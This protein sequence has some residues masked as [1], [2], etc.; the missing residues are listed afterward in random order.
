MQVATVDPVQKP[1]VV[2]DY[3]TVNAA[4]TNFTFQG[5]TTYFVSGSA[6]LVGVTTLEGGAVLKYSIGGTLQI[7]GVLNCETT[8]YRPAVFTSTN[9]NSVGD[10]INGSS[11]SP[12]FEDVNDFLVFDQT[13]V[14]LHDLRFCYSEQAIQD[15]PEPNTYNIWNCQFLNVNMSIWAYDVNLYNVLFG[16]TTGQSSKIYNAGFSEVML[17]GNLNAQNVTSDSGNSFIW[18]LSPG[19]TLA[20]TNCLITSQAITNTDGS[21]APLLTNAVVYLPS[22]TNAVYQTVG[23]GSYYL[24]NGSSYRSYG[25]ANIDLDL[26]VDLM[27]KTTW[28]PLVYSNKTFSVTTNLSPRA[29][30]DNTGYPD[31]GYHYAPIDYIIGASTIASNAAVNLTPGTAVG[32]FR[33][34][35]TATQGLFVSA[36]AQFNSSGTA[37]N[38]CQF[39]PF[40]SVQEGN[41]SW[42]AGSYGMGILFGATTSSHP[43]KMNSKFTI[44]SRLSDTGGGPD[45]LYASMYGVC[46]Y[47][48][49]E[50]YNDAPTTYRPSLY[51][52]N[53]L[54]SRAFVA[55]WDSQNAAS[56][57]FENCTFFN[58]CLSVTR[59]AGQVPSFWLIEN[60]S[61]DGTA[62]ATVD[63]LHGNTNSTLFN[64]NAYNTNNLSWQTYP[65]PYPPATNTLEV[66]GPNDVMVTNYNWQTSWFGNFYLPPDSRL[67]NAGSTTADK[68]GLYHFTTQTNQTPEGTNIVSV[69]YHYVATDTNGIPLDSNGDGIP[70]YLE[71]ANGNG[72]DDPGETNWDIAIL[73][74]PQRINV[75]QGL[76]A[77]F[78]VTV[79]GVGP[80]YYQW[81]MNTNA[82]SG[83]TSS[84]YTALVVQPLQDQSYYSVLVSNLD[85][86]VTSSNAVLGVVTPVAITN[87]PVPLSQA[88]AVG[89]NASFSIG[90]SGNYL[91]YQWYHNSGSIFGATNSI[92]TISGAATS[93]SGTYYVVV[94]N[95]FNS[96]TSS[97]ATLTVL[98]SPNFATNL[99]PSENITQSVDLTLTFAVTNPPPLFFEWY[100][101]NS[102]V[103]PTIVEIGYGDSTYTQLVV[104][105]NNAGLYSVTVTNLV[106]STNGSSLVNVLVPPWISQQA[107][108][109]TVTQGSNATFSISAYGTTN[110]SYQWYE[111]GTTNLI[112]WATSNSM[113]LTNVQG[114]NAGGYFCVVSNLAGTNMSAWAWLS[115]TL[116]GGG[117]T[118]NGWG[119][120]AQ[121]NPPPVVYWLTNTSPTNPY[122]IPLQSISIRAFALS[123]YSYITN[124]SFYFLTNLASSNFLP[125]GN[126]VFGPDAV[127]A[128]AWT[129]FVAG[130]NVLQARA[131]DDLG[132]NGV[133]Q[134]AY[135]LMTTAPNISAETGTNIIW[136]EGTSSTNVTLY[137]TNFDDGQPYCVATNINWTLSKGPKPVSIA[138]SNS[139]TPT[140]T[141]YTN[142]TYDLAF[143]V[144]N[145]YQ[146][147][148]LSCEVK[149]ER[150][151]QISF[152]TPT[153]NEP[154]LTNTPIVLRVSTFAYDGSISNV[155]FYTNTWNSQTNILAQGLQSITNTY[156]Y[157]WTGAPLWT[158]FIS[159]VATDNYGLMA[160]ATTSVVVGPALAV[161]I[162][163]PPNGQLF[164]FSPTNLFLSA[165]ARSFTN[166]I[167]T[168]VTFTNL[169]Q[170]IGLAAGVEQGDGSWQ[171]T[172]VDATNGT[173]TITAT[174]EDNVGNTATSAVTI[175][176]NAMPV[177]SILNPNPTNVETFS[178]ITDVTLHVMAT[179]SDGII[180]NVQFYATNSVSTNNLMGSLTSA[181]GGTNFYNFVWSNRMNGTYP[182]V[183]M[184]TDNRG[185]RTVAGVIFKVNTNN[186]SPSVQIG[187]PTNNQFFVDGSD[188]T[189][190]A[191]VTNFPG[192]VTNVEFF[193]DGESIGN[194]TNAPYNIIQ[195]CWTPGTYILQALATDN[196]GS[197]VASTNVQITVVKEPITGFWD[198]T[199]VS[200][201]GGNPIAISSNAV[202]VGGPGTDGDGAV[203]ETTNNGL[204]WQQLSDLIGGAFSLFADGTNL[205]AGGDNLYPLNISFAVWNG[206]NWAAVGTNSFSGS[207]YA[208]NKIA[209][210]LYVGT[211]DG[212]FELDTN[213]DQWV[214]VGNGFP[215]YGRIYALAAVNNV[216][217]I[218]GDFTDAGGDPNANYIACLVNNTWTNLGSG[219]PALEGEYV[220]SLEGF[221]PNSEFTKVTSLSACGTN[222]FVG[223]WFTSAGNITNANG[224]AV[225]DGESWESLNGGLEPE[226]LPANASPGS[227]T[228]PEVNAILA[229]GNRVFISGQFGAVFNGETTFSA[230]GIAMITWDDANQSWKW[231]DLD[232]GLYEEGGIGGAG[233]LAIVPGASATNYDLYVGDA[234]A[235]L[236]D[237]D[238]PYT[239]TSAG[240]SQIPDSGL[241]RW[242]VGYTY[243]TN[244]PIV[245]ITNPPN[246]TVD[247]GLT[248]IGLIAIVNGDTNITYVQFYANGQQIAYGSGLSGNGA[249]PYVCSFSPTA[250]GVYELIA[251]A[252]D[253]NG[254]NG[255]SLPVMIDVKST[256]NPITAGDVQYRIPENSLPVNFYVLT[257]CSSTNGLTVSQVQ[258]SQF[259]GI[260]SGSLGTPTVGLGGQYIKYTPTPGD[261]GSDYFY[262]T[263]TNAT[264][265][266]DTASVTVNIYPVPQIE[267][268]NPVYSVESVA[269]TSG[270]VALA[271]GGT[272][273]EAA[274][275]A[276]NTNISFFSG[277]IT[278]VSLYVNGVFFARTN[279]PN[280]NFNWSTATS[281]VFTFVA[282]ATDN[283]GITNA[284][285]PVTIISSIISTNGTGSTSTNQVI[286]TITN[287][288]NGPDNLGNS[289]N[290]VVGTGTFDLRGQASASPGGPS[291]P[292]AYQVIL[293]TS[294]G[295]D[296]PIANVTPQADSGG[297]HEGG[298]NNGD[299][300]VINLTGVAN[301]V[302]DLQL[303]V[304]GGGAQ[305]SKTVR[306]ILNT[307]LKIGQFSFSEQDLS[308]PVNGIPVTI[309]RTYNSQ[310]PN[311][312]DFG[313]GWTMALNSMN[314]QLD[315]Q[316]QDVVLGSDQ[317]PFDDNEDID[318]GLPQMLSVRTGGDWDVTL[319]LPNGQQTTFAFGTQLHAGDASYYQ[320]Q[321]TAPPW[322]HAT[323]TP[324]VAGSD[325]IMLYPF[326][327]WAGSDTSYNAPIENQDFPGWILTTSDGTQY[328]ITRGSPTDLIYIPDSSEPPR[329]A[330]LYGP[331]TLTRIIDRNTNSI[332]I[333][334]DSIYHLDSSGTNK[335]AVV[336][337][338]RDDQGRIT[339]ISDP[340]AGPNGIPLVQY[341]YDRDN[342]NLVQVLKLQDRRTGL[343]ATNRY[344]YNNPNY[345]HLITSI[346]NAN[347]VPV[348]RN[349]YGNTGRLIQTIDARGSTNQF[350]YAATNLELTIDTLGRTNSFVYG[351]NGNIIAQTNALGQVTRMAYDSLNNKT[352]EITF[353]NGQPCATN[354][355]SYDANGSL[356]SSTDPL[357]HTNGFTYNG[358]GQPLTSTDARGSA[359]YNGY[360]ANGELTGT[361]DA[362][363]NVTANT[364][365]NGLLAG[366]TDTIGTTTTNYYDLSGN[367][368]NTAT[369]D[370]S[371]NILSSNSYTYD[372]NNNRLT[373]TVWRRVGLNWVPASTTSAYDAQNRVI[374]TINPDGGTNTVIYNLL[375]QQAETIDP[376][377]HTNTFTYDAIGRLIQTIFPD[378]TTNT[379][380]YD[381]A[382][383]RTNSVDQL[384]RPTACVYDALNRLVETIYPDGATNA[385]IYDDLGRVAK[386][387]DA[388]GTITATA[389]DAAGRRTAVTNAFGTSVQSISSYGYDANGNQTTFTDAN[390]HTTTNVY[391]T[392]NRQVQIQYPDGTTAE[393]VYDGDGRSIAQTNQDGIANLFGY[394]GVGRII[395]VT[396]AVGTAQ[397]IVTRYQYDEAGN[398]IVQIDALSRTNFYAYDGQG[399]RTTHAMPGGQHEGFAYDLDGNQLYATNFNGAVITNGYDINNR[400]IGVSSVYGYN[401]S[402]AYSAIG[403]RT[404]MVDSGG[405]NAFVYDNRDRLVLK[406]VSWRSGPTVS[407]NYRYDTDG[408]LTSLWSTN[409]GSVTNIYQYDPLNR[410]TNIVGKLGSLSQYSYDAA[411]NLQAMRYGNGVTNLYQYDT[412]NRLTNCVWNLNASTLAS[413]AYQLGHTG[414]RI[415]LNETTYGT[416][417]NYQWQYDN[418]YRLTNEVFNASSNLFY[419]YDAVGNRLIRQSA[420]VQLP[421][422]SYSYN[423]NDRLTTDSYDSNGNTIQS[424]GTNYQYDVMNHV[425]NVVIGGDHILMTYDG[426]GNRASKTIGATTTYYLLDDRNPSGY[427]QVLEEYTNSSLETVYNYGLDLISEYTLGPLPSTNYFIFDGHG[428]TRLLTDIAGTIQNAFTYDAYGNLIASNAS[429]QTAYL[430]SGQQFDFNLG[431]YL[432]RA[433]YLNPNTGRFWTIDGEGFGNSEDP[434][435]LHKYLY[436]GDDPVNGIDPNGHAEAAD[437]TLSS[438]LMAG[439]GQ[440]AARV[441]VQ[442]FTF[443]LKNPG[444]V[445]AFLIAQGFMTLYAAHEDPS[446]ACLYFE[447]GG[448]A[449]DAAVITSA[450]SDIRSAMVIY[451]NTDGLGRSCGIFARLNEWNIG[452]GSLV[453]SSMKVP[454]WDPKIGLTRGHLLG[455]LLGGLG[456][457]LENL[458]P[459]YRLVNVSIMKRIETQV[460]DAVKAGETVDYRVTPIFEDSSLIPKYIKIEA[461]GDKGLVIT[462]TLENKP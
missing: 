328:Q 115:V 30:R 103:G 387:I 17:F 147:N 64:Y 109:L 407:L 353:L 83:A 411:G 338:G 96:A 335:S 412:L 323:L 105:T 190:T 402:Y 442:G 159:A 141:F 238:F 29:Q 182:A 222:L 171:S 198:P 364:Y 243:P 179:D 295:N 258:E 211:D 92:L 178:N 318:S 430:Y 23:G 91:A 37:N 340:N 142:G 68:L 459:I 8:P 367:L 189:I 455:D 150:R 314:V 461:K 127:F 206:V 148:T 32:W 267:I 22:P 380:A 377:G 28:P 252:T 454:G 362:L 429:P 89:A 315:E 218:G 398:E 251:V 438:G 108:N 326:A 287:L 394:D 241:A 260:H 330:R 409:S 282:V 253:T 268:T 144:G 229:H 343:Y 19:Q 31:I 405:T 93:D 134:L 45:S 24:A 290:P 51:F 205:Y 351:A 107:T 118:T 77:T 226:P 44:Y 286:G 204:A 132:S 344:D 152:I 138:N 447:T 264:G 164:I 165:T 390:N 428:S 223:G 176:N 457:R 329:T 57:T 276:I 352:N 437:V 285:S 228:F 230:S 100:F 379:S 16:Y 266:S 436:V 224:V 416:A 87:G 131:Q 120:G 269:T 413:F 263:V 111:N 359:T 388:R 98:T 200:P 449:A 63:N 85:G 209:G 401:V 110:L 221:V 191:T 391:D 372:A 9:D 336:T 72:V 354:S 375:G 199:F 406:T 337:I 291:F 225:W 172:W 60:S 306:F 254:V 440:F 168:G 280:F 256:N 281:S 419:T 80:F 355:Y 125:A 339:S 210:V 97:N 373:S 302:Y 54:F 441:T 452:G 288:R 123:Q 2:L 20:L 242:R 427:I 432:N 160:T 369:L 177:L 321:W 121:T 240:S 113:T 410:L 48:D 50:F 417:R 374:E 137:G 383:N 39:F 370:V 294:D 41:G 399:R 43:P 162:T 146:S 75:P 425:T 365:N 439:L 6:Y 284:S 431:L 421:T 183:V 84:N 212:L 36:G 117:G 25:T 239:F 130:T 157:L 196:Y 236:G 101:S 393:T 426:D 104:Q 366:S 114:T 122:I 371:G 143:T 90:A 197:L 219:I 345:P 317:A 193:V 119:S 308:L 140:V 62:F 443:A 298:D 151:P 357:G 135:V 3:V 255:A 273:F 307:Q 56:F 203:F 334:P 76:N 433:R 296:T 181:N 319:T 395:A 194:V 33:R 322:I 195:C 27:Q 112:S 422:A 15:S 418:L 188:I 250:A 392:L 363:N 404:N 244:L 333:N 385:T 348:T 55:F 61:F 415:S 361:T 350:I 376:L 155:I 305:T 320:A 71:D 145:G 70:D 99:P 460:R 69:G 126:G 396:N 18:P 275:G 458:T 128:L 347:G 139:L 331:P 21:G 293:C 149:V 245:T 232:G 153:S 40:S 301:G 270:V 35:G 384:G 86:C 304:Y 311:S 94:T 59:S 161:W 247:M 389:Y 116:S 192:S 378:G 235:A 246:G 220:F 382:G 202:Y 82:I 184:A 106:G 52:T 215:N 341:I 277:S 386:T 265:A 445:R 274:G 186:P 49:C 187:P 450:A 174:A 175:T 231:S 65:Y 102:V 272:S 158:N 1:G 169:T 297:F 12:D 451:K 259:S 435:S 289:T 156:A 448:F 13:N 423:T 342:G 14:T 124:V 262:Y 79:A 170:S 4:K 434:L 310:N 46:T 216:L 403:Q 453:P 185:A 349:Y 424:A 173:Y 95:L 462:R 360:D 299:L 5:D 214:A 397:Q 248:N 271:I 163:A 34:N 249:G 278:N 38:P 53:C 74:Q 327:N 420:I 303:S 208:I 309:A 456:T 324:L 154:F 346:E 408:N 10:I 234:S 26:L 292:V 233:S 279:N 312:A 88:L 283:N 414:N 207:P 358:F 368:T 201:G 237:I 81:F 227:Q 67:T 11:G 313:Y 356:L 300:G 167:V 381:D 42:Q 7:G 180:T 316:R 166:T 261:I 446:Q 444:L 213:S 129:N 332:V 47:S 78:S 325:Q 58:G 217:Y 133:S 73:V 66:I 136:I 400:L 257:N